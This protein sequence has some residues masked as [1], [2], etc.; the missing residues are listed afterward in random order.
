MVIV[1]AWKEFWYDARDEGPVERGSDLEDFSFYCLGVLEL[2][3][4]RQT[5]RRNWE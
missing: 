5:Y 2:A 1:A 4:A 3:D